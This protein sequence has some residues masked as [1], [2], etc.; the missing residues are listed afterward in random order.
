MAGSVDT[1]ED[2]LE[3]YDS[4]SR[5]AL[6]RLLDEIELEAQQI[7][8]EGRRRLIDGHA[9]HGSA[10]FDRDYFSLSSEVRKRLADAVIAEAAQMRYLDAPV[11]PLPPILPSV[12]PQ[13]VR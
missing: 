3:L 7:I 13:S 2:Q 10:L 12:V 11:A 1:I 9:R 5:Q 8:A 6:G 4:S